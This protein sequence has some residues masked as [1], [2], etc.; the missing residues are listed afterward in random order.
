MVHFLCLCLSPSHVDLVIF[1]LFLL[2]SERIYT[3]FFLGGDYYISDYKS[4]VCLLPKHYSNSSECL[5]ILNSSI[6]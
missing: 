5:F 3:N 6:H 4:Y 2:A 1:L